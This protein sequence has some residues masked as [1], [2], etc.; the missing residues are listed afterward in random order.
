MFRPECDFPSLANLALVFAT[1]SASLD[2]VARILPENSLRVDSARSREL[3]A[4][5]FG[6]SA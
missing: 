4:L 6:E 2:V 3:S 1:F 5:K